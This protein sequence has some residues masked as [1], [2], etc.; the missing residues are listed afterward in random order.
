MWLGSC[1]SRCITALGVLTP[2]VERPMVDIWTESYILC[3]CVLCV[4]IVY[5]SLSLSLSGCNRNKAVKSEESFIAVVG[6]KMRQMRPY[7]GI[8]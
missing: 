2:A 5:D 4:Y 8:L 3:F 1:C 6:N 7:P